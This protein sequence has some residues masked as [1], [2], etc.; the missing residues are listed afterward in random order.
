MS[1]HLLLFGAPPI[2]L[3]IR[4]RAW[5]L[6]TLHLLL[7]L[8]TAS[9]QSPAFEPYHLVL[10]LCVEYFLVA[11]VSAVVKLTMMSLKQTA[12]FDLQQGPFLMKLLL[13]L[14]LCCFDVPFRI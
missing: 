4:A 5:M 9:T 3:A 2:D 8:I 12:V 7:A 13:S 1:V 11:E 14:S 10:L 6:T